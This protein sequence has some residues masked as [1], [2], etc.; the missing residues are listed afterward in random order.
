MEIAFVYRVFGDFRGYGGLDT[1][2][3]G[4]IREK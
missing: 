1:R 2:I 3:L 4:Q